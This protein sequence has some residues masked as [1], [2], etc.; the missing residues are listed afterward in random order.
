MIDCTPLRPPQGQHGRRR[1]RELGQFGCGRVG[2]RRDPQRPCRADAPEVTGRGS[3]GGRRQDRGS[4]GAL[5]GCGSD[6]GVVVDSPADSVVDLRRARC[7]R[8]RRQRDRTSYPSRSASS[9]V[10]AIRT[11]VRGAQ[12]MSLRRPV[13]R[14]GPAASLVQQADL[15]WSWRGGGARPERSRAATR[16]PPGETAPRRTRPR[17]RLPLRENARQYS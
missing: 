17:G 8:W 15:R 3:R 2:W 16:N 4:R 11:P 1:P 12:V 13:A 14:V 5:S 9:A 6:L 10:K 7:R